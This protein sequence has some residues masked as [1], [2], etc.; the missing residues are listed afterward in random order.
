M[1]TAIA[2]LAV[3]LGILALLLAFGAVY[4]AYPGNRG[5]V[6]AIEPTSARVVREFARANFGAP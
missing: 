5:H 4:Q 3:P 6:G 1:H 2:I